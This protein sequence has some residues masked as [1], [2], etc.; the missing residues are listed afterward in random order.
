MTIVS[1]RLSQR[2]RLRKSFEFKQVKRKGMRFRDN[3]LWVQGYVDESVGA[4]KIGIIAT[5]RLG[6]A[7]RRNLAKRRMRE[8]FRQSQHLVKPGS[9]IVVLPRTESLA[10]S[11]G[12]LRKRF[13]KLISS[14]F[15]EK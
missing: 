9:H 12:E 11:Y 2:M 8:L 4:K 15:M 5:K 10:L 3:A 14:T 6:G 13:L 1:N 7:V